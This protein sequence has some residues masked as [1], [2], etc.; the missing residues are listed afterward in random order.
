MSNPDFSKGQEQ[1]KDCL[2]IARFAV[3]DFKASNATETRDRKIVTD[4]RLR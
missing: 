2:A 3:A 4:I 1:I